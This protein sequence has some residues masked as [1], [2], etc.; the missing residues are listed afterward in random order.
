[1]TIE[2]L[3]FLL[4]RYNLS[5]NKLKGQN[6]LIDEEVLSEI[7]DTA[8]L[9][10]DD[11]VLEVG[12]GLGA[13]TAKLVA[14][15]RQVVAFE[16]DHNFQQPL[17]KLSKVS[18]NL[19]IVWQD[20]LSVSQEQWQTILTKYQ[21]TNYKIV[22]NIPYYLTGKFIQK[23]MLFDIAPSSLT[24]MLQKEVAERLVAKDN[25]HSL[26]SLAVAFYGQVNIA[27]LVSKNSFYPV[28][29]VDSAIVHIDSLKAWTHPAEEKFTWQLVHRGFAQKRKKLINNILTDTRL[30][31]IRVSQA[32]AT[33]NLDQNIRAENLSPSEWLELAQQLQF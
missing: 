23:F 15:V 3:K 17:D 5:P 33:L 26:L 29:Q 32:F 22:A 10:K 30:D 9:E 7:I 14:Q 27:A 6:F 1:M 19:E 13:L 25:K 24:L 8:D 21:A 11:L 20:I 18:Q 16:V 2:E 28:P 31:K 4:N 12:P